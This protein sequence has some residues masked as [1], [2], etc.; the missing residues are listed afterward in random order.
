MSRD[1]QCCNGDNPACVTSLTIGELYG[2]R[3]CHLV[4]GRGCWFLYNTLFPIG[5]ASAHTVNDLYC[6]RCVDK[7]GLDGRTVSSC[8]LL[9][10]TG[11]DIKQNVEY[12]EACVGAFEQHST[13]IEIAVDTL[14]RNKEE[15]L[16]MCEQ[17]VR[18]MNTTREDI[19]RRRVSDYDISDIL[20]PK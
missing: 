3:N 7:K 9:K 14:E 12:Y 17:I 18:A 13:P 6:A 19:K 2:C 1:C 20:K 5:K 10:R 11:I 4:I 8:C 16:K 15:G